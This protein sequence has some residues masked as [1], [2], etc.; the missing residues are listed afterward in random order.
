[1]IGHCSPAF[2]AGEQL[3]RLNQSSIASGVPP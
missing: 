3:D 2:L 1:L